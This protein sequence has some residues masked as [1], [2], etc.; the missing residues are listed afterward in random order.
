M[1]NFG[2]C[3]LTPL[4]VFECAYFCFILFAPPHTVVVCDAQPMLPPSSLSDRIH[5]DV[6]VM[7]LIKKREKQ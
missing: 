6:M 1:K 4:A 5:L 3:S 7:R 2:K